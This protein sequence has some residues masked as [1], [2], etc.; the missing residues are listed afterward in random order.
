MEAKVR[1][2]EI[3]MGDNGDSRSEQSEAE[4][5]DSMP[6]W[7][8]AL[9]R[10]H[11]SMIESNATLAKT[12]GRLARQVRRLNGVVTHLTGYQREDPT[13]ETSEEE[14]HK[15]HQKRREEEPPMVSNPLIP[16]DAPAVPTAPVSGIPYPYPY[17]Y[18]YFFTNLDD[19]F[20]NPI[21]QSDPYDQEL[22]FMDLLYDEQQQLEKSLA[23]MVSEQF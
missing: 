5:D 1:E 4:R 22:C 21:A 7:A 16:A 11:E 18:P 19:Y 8:Q 20:F 2:E 9:I 10:L 14:E 3:E 23:Q 12:V 13:K 17:P 15:H 6:S